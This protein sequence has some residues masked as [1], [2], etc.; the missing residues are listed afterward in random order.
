[1]SVGGRSTCQ[2]TS[3]R[4]CLVHFPFLWLPSFDRKIVKVLASCCGVIDPIQLMEI[5]MATVKLCLAISPVVC[6]SFSWLVHLLPCKLSKVLHTHGKT[7]RNPLSLRKYRG[8]ASICRSLRVVAFCATIVSLSIHFSLRYGNLQSGQLNYSSPGPGRLVHEPNSRV[9]HHSLD[10]VFHSC[11]HVWAL[12]VQFS[13]S[14]LFYP[15]LG[16]PGE[17]PLGLVSLNITSLVQNL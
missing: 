17:G 11:F 16:Y 15:C 3:V 12:G 1:M 4:I 2:L 13:L 9:S 14:L 10:E 8:R 7:T 5:V 6:I